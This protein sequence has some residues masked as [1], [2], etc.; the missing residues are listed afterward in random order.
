MRCLLRTLFQPH[1][2]AI[3]FVVLAVPSLLSAAPP[4]QVIGLTD[5]AHQGQ[6]DQ[7]QRVNAAGQVIGFANRVFNT[8]TSSYLGHDLWYFDPAIGATRIIGLSDP[9]HTNGY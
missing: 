3:A 6:N 2:A 9:A 4:I 5:P 1:S 8:G 7:P